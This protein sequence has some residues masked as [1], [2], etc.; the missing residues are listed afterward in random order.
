MTYAQLSAIQYLRNSAA[1]VQKLVVRHALVSWLVCAV[2]QLVR[3]RSCESRVCAF[4]CSLIQMRVR[5]QHVPASRIQRLSYI[6]MR[7]RMA[8][9]REREREREDTARS[10]L[11]LLRSSALSLSLPPSLSLSLI[12]SLHIYIICCFTC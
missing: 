9:E 2:V 5:L 6:H 1:F 10:S 11:S 8:I 3:A 7:V 12:L 4:S